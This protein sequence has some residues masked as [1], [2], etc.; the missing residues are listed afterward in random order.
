MGNV[1]PIKRKS[2]EVISQT[3]LKEFF[4]LEQRYL[5]AKSRYLAKPNDYELEERFVAVRG[6]YRARR[7]QLRHQL[8]HGAKQ[9][10]GKFALLPKV[11]HR[12]SVS[13]KS[14]VIRLKGEKYQQALL[15]RAT[16]KA[17]TKLE[18]AEIGGNR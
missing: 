4:N 16:P 2:D 8:D 11:F 3:A 9:A 14:E 5:D 15:A 12:R 18:F 6:D 13:Y 1:V 7:D 10:P 17:Y